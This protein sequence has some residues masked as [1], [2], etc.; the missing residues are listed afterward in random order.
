MRPR[1]FDDLAVRNSA[2]AAETLEW[3]TTYYAF[4]KEARGQ[5]PGHR[6]A[7][8]RARTAPRLNELKFYLQTQLPAIS[9]KTPRRQRS[10]MR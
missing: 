1:Y 8:L 9:S 2:I 6:L 4:Q 3:I 7:I 10:A 5:P